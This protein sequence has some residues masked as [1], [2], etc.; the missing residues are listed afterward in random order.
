[1]QL[2]RGWTQAE[3]GGPA[4]RYTDRCSV[5]P[6]TAAGRIL[7]Y[8]GLA[9]LISFAVLAWDIDRNGIA[10]AYNDPISHIRA[11][12]EAYH[13]NSAIRMTQDGDWMTP[14]LLGRLFLFKPPL[15]IWLSALSIRLFGLSLLSVRLPALVL[16]A[17]G[18]AA[19]FA[20]SARA[21]SVTAGVLAAGVLLCSPFWQTFSRLCFTDVL[22]T[23]FAAL[24]LAGAAFDPAL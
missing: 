20:W 23:S 1:M 12:D 19:V 14:K 5:P 13:F 2:A 8:A 6:I 24:A 17:A 16:G 21:R 4:V 18:T 9:F 10:A 7:L 11:E 15:L 22:Y 3:S